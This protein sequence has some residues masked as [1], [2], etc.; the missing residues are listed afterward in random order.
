[1]STDECPVQSILAVGLGLMVLVRLRDCRVAAAQTTRLYQ[2]MAAR[3]W[4]R[5]HSCGACEAAELHLVALMW[6]IFG[7]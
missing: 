3:R 1:M 5:C 7:F 4:L 6:H 2:P